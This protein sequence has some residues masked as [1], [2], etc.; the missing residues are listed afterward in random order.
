MA[1]DPREV[2]STVWLARNLGVSRNHLV[3]VLQRL[4]R[5]GMVRPVRGPRGGYVLK[6]PPGRITLRRVMEALEGRLEP[7][8]C[9]L[10]RPV[11]GGHCLLAPVFRA[12]N[13]RLVSF[14]TTT[15]IAELAARWSRQNGGITRPG[16]GKEE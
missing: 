10:H 6:E 4:N 9:M 15:N 14:F 1:G 16:G 12:V 5:A 11:C 7:A 3:K 2:Y 13:Q 8:G